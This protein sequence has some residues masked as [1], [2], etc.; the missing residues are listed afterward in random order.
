VAAVTAVAAV[1]EERRSKLPVRERV[2]RLCD[3]GAPFLELSPLAGEGLG[4]A[5][6]LKEESVPSAGVVTG[7]GLVNGRPVMVL[8]NDPAVKG[9]TM[10]PV[11]VK[12]QLRAQE[13]ARENRLPC[14]YLVDSGGAF[15]PLQAD[16]FPDREHG[17]RVFYNEARMSASGIAQVAVVLG[18]CTAGAAYIPAMCD[19]TVIVAGQ[20][21]IFLAGPPLV[22]AATGEVVSG[23]ELGGGDMHTRRSGV[24][25]HLAKDEDDAFAIARRIL[26]RV[27][28]EPRGIGAFETLEAAG[29][30]APR[31]IVRLAR[32]R[33]PFLLREGAGAPEPATL[34]ALA[35]TRLPWIALRDGDVDGPSLRSFSPRFLFSLPGSRVAG[36]SAREASARLFDDGLVEEEALAPLLARLSEVMT[37]P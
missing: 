5:Y 31:A 6:G 2:A 16:I 17:G 14:V 3:S 21:T 18:S 35:Q 33:R 8:A 23:E 36:L 34:R 4:P 20:G 32:E 24:A 30:K 10:F 25:D 1:S 28:Q 9:G 37:W 27:P 11:S 13:I 7:I 19:E 26:E 22:L 12:K 29:P 15:L